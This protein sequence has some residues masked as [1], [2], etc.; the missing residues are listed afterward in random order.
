MT[1]GILHSI[2]IL[3]T[4]KQLTAELTTNVHNTYNSECQPMHLEE[5]VGKEVPGLLCHM[6]NKAHSGLLKLRPRRDRLWAGL[7]KC[8][9]LY[10]VSIASL[11]RLLPVAR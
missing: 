3:Y 5:R 10:Q 8:R 2:K 11:S 6:G 1:R 4:D 7:L 9:S